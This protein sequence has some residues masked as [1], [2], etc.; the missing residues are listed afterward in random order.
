VRQKGTSSNSK[1]TAHYAS[2]REQRGNYGKAE[3]GGAVFR[4]RPSLGPDFTAMRRSN[5]F[6]IA[7]HEIGQSLLPHWWV[8]LDW[9][10]FKKS[11]ENHGQLNAIIMYER[12]ILDGRA[13]YTACKELE[14]PYWYQRY[15]GN[16]PVGLWETRN[17]IRCIMT[18][19]EFADAVAK[20]KA[21]YAGGSEI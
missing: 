21:A 14:R 9:L 20:L 18:L 19:E 13:R 3:K 7:F 11:M 10:G 1:T 6:R 2:G 17:S 4:C 12:K 5:A 15:V 8:G 16:D